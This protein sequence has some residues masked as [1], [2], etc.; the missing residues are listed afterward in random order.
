MK[1]PEAHR[2]ERS[3]GVDSGRVRVV[4][5]RLT[6]DN[7][8]ISQTTA[9]RPTHEERLTGGLQ[10]PST[11]SASTLDLSDRHAASRETSKLVA[12]ASR[13]TLSSLSGGNMRMTTT[14][15]I[16]HNTDD[17][18][19][20]TTSRSVLSDVVITDRTR[21]DAQTTLMD[22]ETSQTTTTT[23]S[24]LRQTVVTDMA[25]PVRRHNDDITTMTTIT[26]TT[27][28]TTTS[29]TCTTTSSS[30][31]GDLDVFNVE[32]TLPEMDWDRLEQQLRHAVELERRA[33]VRLV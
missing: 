15:D 27:S 9:D 32:S 13:R 24:E 5:G 10:R 23:T 25:S 20:D 21:E 6:A 2:S 14:R 19:S 11:S 1:P 18:W 30:S 29:S 3:S 31:S 12:D 16:C 17:N 28:T 7:D 33:E 4:D 26:T 22:D 8:H